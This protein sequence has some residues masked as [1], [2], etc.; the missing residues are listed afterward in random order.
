[1]F[2][3][4]I[5][6]GLLIF[7]LS[8]VQ[9]LAQ[10]KSEIATKK[11]EISV[12]LQQ[13]ALGLLRETIKE[14]PYLKT[15]ENQ[16]YFKIETA[17]LL[18]KYDEKEARQMFQTE[19]T[20]IRNSISKIV[21]EVSPKYT[22][23]VIGEKY[24]RLEMNFFLKF[25]IISS[26][27]G[28]LIKNLAEVEPETA[29]KFLVETSQMLPKLEGDLKFRDMF[30]SLEET[31]IR[32]FL[33]RGNTDKAVEVARRMMTEDFSDEFVTQIKVIYEKDDQKGNHF[34]EEVLQKIK[35]AK[36]NTNQN[37]I[38]KKFL[39]A[40]IESKK[41]KE[42]TP[43]LSDNSIRDLADF[44]GQ[45]VLAIKKINY[46]LDEP[47]EYADLIEKY[48]PQKAEQIRQKYKKNL[49]ANEES[50]ADENQL[51]ESVQKQIASS[52]ENIKKQ[53]SEI[54]KNEDE[55]KDVLQKLEN[56]KFSVQEKLQITEQIKKL[57]S[58]SAKNKRR[59]EKVKALVMFAM[60]SKDREIIEVIMNEAVALTNQQTKSYEDY[61]SNWW[62]ASGYSSFNTE[63]SFLI[64]EDTIPKFNEVIAGFTKI[65]EFMDDSNSIFANGEIT[66]I[67]GLGEGIGANFFKDLTNNQVVIQNLAKSD[68][69]R[70]KKL[71]DQFER[72]EFR[73]TA[74]MF[75]LDS[76]L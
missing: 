18:W 3:Q 63:K 6:T 15:E 37:Y 54:K 57:V 7:S 62:L 20:T 36:I 50:V 61:M 38:I 44:L 45:S 56:N 43:L 28:L 76:L 66:M 19:M 17:R 26:L 40:A 46:T 35:T 39:E 27:R 74:R 1:M 33:M 49:P 48:A 59:N 64:L 13:K 70:T 65:A 8:S 5:F 42:Q 22:N 68:F 4:K 53:A 2:I 24:H 12:E 73:L 34:A 14:I 16:Q 30:H 47:F 41:G 29:Y 55:E 51:N 31:I 32:S 25:E 9:I 60:S 75:V 52:T 69:N 71:T 10:Q 72:I 21:S 11:T 23:S 67:G 58:E